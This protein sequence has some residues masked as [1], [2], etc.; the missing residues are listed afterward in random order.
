MINRRSL[1]MLATASGVSRAWAPESHGIRLGVVTGIGGDADAAIARVRRLGFPTCFLSLRDVGSEIAPRLKDALARYSVEATALESLGPGQMVWDLVRGP[2]TIGL[3][4]PQTR[5]ARIDHLCRTSDLA[6]ALGIPYV[7]THGGFI[8]EIETDALYKGA[9]EAVGAVAK[10]CK[11]NRQ[12]FLLETGQESPVTLLRAIQDTGLDN[13]GVGLDTA[14][15]ILYGKGNPV[16]ALDVLGKYVRSVHAKDGLFPT[17]PRQLGKEVS[18]GT[19]RVD[20][21]RVISRLIELGYAG[22]ISI[23]REISGP[24]QE[25]DIR[26]AK[27][28][29]ENIINKAA[30]V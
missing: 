18:I 24:R 15:L 19:G 12:E 28:F 1:L 22:A 4:P 11:A 3:V 20:F 8:P 23:E 17:N 9:V 29:L 13:V 26:Q 21:G 30:K 10:H 27:T 2:S 16:D 7:Q 14:N 25:A 6:A 5:Q